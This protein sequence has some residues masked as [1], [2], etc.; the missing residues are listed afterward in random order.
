MVDQQ[1]QS[2]PAIHKLVIDCR[3][4]SI[5]KLDLQAKLLGLTL[6][7]RLE[8]S[9]HKAGFSE[10]IWVE[11]PQ[12]YEATD[13]PIVPAHW[14]GEV[15]W[16]K[17]LKSHGD[18]NQVQS[19]ILALVHPSDFVAAENRLIRNLVKDTDGFM[20]RHVA[21]PIS[22]YVSRR[23]APH[24][25]SPN[26][27]TLVSAF[28]G[29]MGAPFF[30]SDNPWV[31]VWGGFLFMMHS[32]LD[33][34]DGELARLKFQE[35]RFGGLLDF[36]GDNVVHVAVFFCMAYGWYLSSGDPFWPI[37]LGSGALIGAGGSAMAV[38]WLTLRKK[39]ESGPVY[40]SVSTGPG[41]TLSKV[42]D[43]LSRRDFI[44]GVF[45]LTMFGKGDWFLVPTSIGSLVFL[46][47]VIHLARK[48]Q[49]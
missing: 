25:I 1:S 19:Q 39:Q 5:G 26:Q 21:R 47:L 20:S 9:A 31:E 44:Y 14:L 48:G 28:I 22:L 34:C 41:S 45:I 30:L 18:L 8:K 17:Q 43:D 2:T 23:L 7:E 27:M 46:G 3:L 24:P 15:G 11:D 4:A 40:T 35:S 38:Y 6:R 36:A 49:G 37:L 33:G 32:I 29:L 13:A 10:I 12:D 16:L 42:L